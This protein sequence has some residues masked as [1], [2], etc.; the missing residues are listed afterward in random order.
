MKKALIIIAVVLV[1]I[2]IYV[3]IVLYVAYQLNNVPK[4]YSQALIDIQKPSF[5][6]DW[7]DKEETLPTIK[8]AEQAE[9][10]FTEIT[11]SDIYNSGYYEPFDYTME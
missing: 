4:P 7:F 8:T 10:E 3:G 11:A 5:T 2:L 1:P 9:E 6:I